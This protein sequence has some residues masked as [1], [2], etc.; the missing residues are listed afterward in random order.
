MRERAVSRDAEE[1]AA[2]PPAAAAPSRTPFDRLVDVEGVGN[3]A[4]GRVLRRQASGAADQPVPHGFADRLRASEAGGQP[5]P[6]AAAGRL[7]AGTGMSLRD[8]RLHADAAAAT[9]AANVGASAFTVG[10]HI[11]FGRGRYNPGSTSGYRLLAHE[12]AHTIQDSGGTGPLVVGAADA[13]AER[14]ADTLAGHLASHQGAAMASLSASPTVVRRQPEPG[15]SP[16]NRDLIEQALRTK[17]PSDVKSIPD[18][19]Q[20]NEGEKLALLRILVDQG[21][22]GPRDELVIEQIWR[23]F[24]DRLATIASA[25]MPLWQQCMDRGAEL[26]ELPQVVALQDRF[27]TDVKTV[28]TG[29]LFRNRQV[30]LDEMQRLGLPL[31][32][33]AP[34]PEATADQQEQTR[35]LQAAAAAAAKLQKA[36]EQARRIFVGYEVQQAVAGNEPVSSWVPVPFDP[37]APPQFESAPESFLVPV[38][39]VHTVPYREVKEKYDQATGLLNDLLVR[40][41]SLFAL[42]REGSS[43]VTA[44]FAARTDPQQAR[45]QL[46]VATRAVIADIEATQRKLDGGD[47]E[48]L[49]LQPIHEQLFA[50]LAGGSAVRWGD[51]LPRWAAGKLVGDHNFN[52]ALIALGMNTAS[53]AMFML[54]PFTGGASLYLMLGGLAVT[55]TKFYLSSQ[56]YEALAQAAGTNVDPATKLVT[57]GQVEA[58]ELTRTAD[59]VALALAALAVGEVAATKAIGAIRAAGAGTAATEEAAATA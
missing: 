6:D 37:N 46:A 53:A 25:N 44:G 33:G 59:L 52:Q 17:D 27:V 20:A 15:A 24:G 30:V 23:S 49:D 50:G 42:T 8:V 39:R 41:P 9:M 55:G 57:P 51:A 19:G 13:P 47:L 54:A 12:V 35:Q 18:V 1:V 16:S 56:Q 10:Q 38:V 34:V 7:E 43:D 36:Q 58:A 11:Y 14:E 4:V 28:V 40:Y 5:I 2:V 21:W 48:P 31:E 3:Q 22:V 45:Q 29:Y 26:D 32:A